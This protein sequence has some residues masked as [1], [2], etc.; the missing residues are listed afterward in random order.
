VNTDWQRGLFVVQFV[1]T[2]IIF[3]EILVQVRRPFPAR[4]N[5]AW[6][7]PVAA[8]LRLNFRPRCAA[9]VYLVW[10]LVLPLHQMC[11]VGPD[12][13]RGS[14]QVF[15]W[16]VGIVVRPKPSAQRAVSVE[17]FPVHAQ[18]TEALLRKSTQTQAAVDF[19][20]RVR[21]AGEGGGGGGGVAHLLVRPVC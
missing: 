16:G 2:C 9:V 19:L 15:A 18:S 20:K 7:L 11:W 1:T 8:C 13:F 4:V 3:T 5:L 6:A 10:G 14:T 12:A 21:G 17:P